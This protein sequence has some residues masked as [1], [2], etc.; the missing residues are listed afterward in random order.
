MMFRPTPLGTASRRLLM[1]A[2]VSLLGLAH[3]T[4]APAQQDRVEGA[5]S[6]RAA[7]QQKP[8]VRVIATVRPPQAPAAA[9]TPEVAA[10][11]SRLES[12]MRAANARVEPVVG[13]PFVVVEVDGAGLQRLIDSGEVV[14]VQEDIPEATQLAQSGPLVRAP[15]AG[16]QGARGAGTAVAV[17]DTGVDAGHSFLAGKVVAEA[18]F[19]T[20]SPSQGS[21]SVCPDG[22]GQQI[23]A[24]AGQPCTVGGCDHGTHVAGIAAGRG[25]GFSGMAPDANIVA[26]QVFS[27]F[28]DRLGGPTHCANSGRSSPCVL[29]FVSDQ[30]KALGHVRDIAAARGIASANMSLGGGK[31][32]SACPGD[33]RQP[34]IQALRAAGVATAIASGNDG[35]TDAVGTPGCIPEAVTVGSVT[36]TDTV[37]GFSNSAPMVDLL[38]P[39]SSINSSVP[40]GGFAAFNGTSMAT[41]HTAGAVAALRSAR[42]DA[43]IDQIEDALKASG[44]PVT[45]PRNGLTRPRIDIAAALDRLP[46]ASPIRG[47]A[48]KVE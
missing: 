24:G 43:T 9:E 6:V 46:A 28:D 13:L 48:A 40:G 18:C 15:D 23:G 5:A 16:A 44:Q 47:A 32:T 31:N 25:T 20:T 10:A 29:T 11:K 21:T 42:H 34:S 26:I 12:T 36:K 35:F 37:S 30:L 45:D 22:T 17:L 38:A 27:R 19:S 8:V 3:A 41:P 7:V 2:G 14:A 1:L 4:P 39:G 33:L